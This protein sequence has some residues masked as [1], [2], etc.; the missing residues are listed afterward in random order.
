MKRSGVIASGVLAVLLAA[1]SAERLPGW[2]TPATPQQLA[3]VTPGSVTGQLDENS[4]TLE[5]GRY[6]AVHP[7]EG[8]A[9]ETVTFEL[10][11]D[12]FDVFIGLFS[13]SGESL[14]H[15]ILLRLN[16]SNN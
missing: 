16:S 9:G 1:G 6:I 14:G 12:D 3:Q 7:Y 8:V 10:V 11:S 2:A 13:P 5:D 4:Q 15:M